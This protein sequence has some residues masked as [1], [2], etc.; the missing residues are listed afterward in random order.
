MKL[1]WFLSCVI[2]FASV[3]GIVYF[4]GDVIK[5]HLK[6]P[7]K[8]VEE[9]SERYEGSTYGILLTDTGEYLRQ[10]DRVKEGMQKNVLEG[11]IAE[12]IFSDKYLDYD[13]GD[14]DKW[15]FATRLTNEYSALYNAVPEKPQ[16]AIEVPY[17]FERFRA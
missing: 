5:E 17:I 15:W 3:Y 13:L 4:Y 6:E 7:I 1:G 8:L 14:F 16:L 11:I 2:S 10:D 12:F 9:I